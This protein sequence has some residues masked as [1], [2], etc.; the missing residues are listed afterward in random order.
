MSISN[1][2]MEIFFQG[3]DFI[4]GKF[5]HISLNVPTTRLEDSAW[6]KTGWH[7]SLQDTLCLDLH[8]PVERRHPT[9]KQQQALMRPSP[10]ASWSAKKPTKRNLRRFKKHQ[11]KLGR[12]CHWGLREPAEA[13][14]RHV[15]PCSASADLSGKRIQFARFVSMSQ[16]IFGLRHL[17]QL[18]S[19]RCS[20]ATLARVPLW[21]SA[22]M[23]SCWGVQLFCFETKA[24]KTWI[25][26][27]SGKQHGAHVNM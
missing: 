17:G 20:K 15:W 3:C 6:H 24:V 21:H 2:C 13:I 22:E 5:V 14:F 23:L 26:Y 10:C 8:L 18:T 12:N 1:L 19:P 9:P 27:E 4:P 16:C 25:E 7:T 11:E